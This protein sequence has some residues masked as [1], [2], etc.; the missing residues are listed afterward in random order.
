MVHL[1]EV[2]VWGLFFFW[3]GAFANQSTAFYFALNE[4]TTVGSNFSLPL[5][6]RLLEGIIASVGLLAF[7]LSTGVLF[8]LA[9]T[10]LEQPIIIFHRHRRQEIP[11][12]S[13]FV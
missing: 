3:K 2:I 4:Y 8:S 1:S 7:A 9:K 13:G 12:L 10:F 5:H 11:R 6:W